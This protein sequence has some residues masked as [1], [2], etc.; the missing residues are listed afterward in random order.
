[1]Y[2]WCKICLQKNNPKHLLTI[3]QLVQSK[4][5]CIK[6]TLMSITLHFHNYIHTLFALYLVGSDWTGVNRVTCQAKINIK[7]INEPCL[8][9]HW[10]TCIICNMYFY[11]YLQF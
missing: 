1:M 4:L 7:N 6:N 10:Y 11:K 3:K 2:F 5:I 8:T 9:E